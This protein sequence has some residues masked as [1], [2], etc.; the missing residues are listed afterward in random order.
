MADLGSCPRKARCELALWGLRG[1]ST[2]RRR[3][4]APVVKESKQSIRQPQRLTQAAVKFL[5]GAGTTGS[6]YVLRQNIWVPETPFLFSVHIHLYLPSSPIER[7]ARC[8]GPPGRSCHGHT[9]PPGCHQGQPGHRGQ[10]PLWKCRILAGS[11]HTENWETERMHWNFALDSS[12]SKD[13]DFTEVFT[14]LRESDVELS[15]NYT[16]AP[17]SWWPV[18]K[19]VQFRYISHFLPVQSRSSYSQDQPN[20]SP[21]DAAYLQPEK[22][23]VKKVAIS[24]WFDFL[25]NKNELHIVTELNRRVQH[26]LS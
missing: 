14:Q 21:T 16:P 1:R 22:K 23:K 17:C 19:K 8:Q 7:A 3:T 11:G 4:K 24:F 15:G 26:V 25:S 5:L 13:L 12:S 18:E 6:L 9:S 10:H 2:T 20:W